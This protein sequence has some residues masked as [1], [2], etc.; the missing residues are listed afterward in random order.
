MSKIILPNWILN[1]NLV[2]FLF[3]EDLN[4]K[5][6]HTEFEKIFYKKN[7]KFHHYSIK[8]NNC[9]KSNNKSFKENI[10]EEIME[11]LEK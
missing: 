1:D 3:Q 7:K 2:K 8:L 10:F 9:L 6:L 4:T 11:V 5:N